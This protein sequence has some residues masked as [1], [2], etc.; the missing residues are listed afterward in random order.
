MSLALRSL[1][2]MTSSKGGRKHVDQAHMRKLTSAD[3]VRVTKYYLTYQKGRLRFESNRGEKKMK[4]V[5]SAISAFVLVGSLVGSAYAVD[6]NVSL[7]ES[8]D[9][10]CH[11]KFPAIRP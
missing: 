2:R 5:G 10:Y 6:N 4:K 11:F 3:G 8:S 1:D 7:S 9:N